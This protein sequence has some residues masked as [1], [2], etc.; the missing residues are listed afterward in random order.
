[1]LHLKII[2]DGLAWWGT[3]LKQV[4]SPGTLPLAIF[5]LTAAQEGA[6]R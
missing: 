2:I 1:M 6:R 4:R 3:A 5:R